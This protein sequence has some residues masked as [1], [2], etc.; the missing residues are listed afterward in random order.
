VATKQAL[1]AQGLHQVIL[2]PERSQIMIDQALFKFETQRSW[3][4]LWN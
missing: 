4:T 2:I 1:M 3:K